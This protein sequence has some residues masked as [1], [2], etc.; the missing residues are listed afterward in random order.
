MTRSLFIYWKAGREHAAA[1]AADAL[2]AQRSL[3]QRHPGLKAR[4][5]RRA[6]EAGATV[7]LMETY[8]RPGGVGAALQAEI[9]LAGARAGAPWCQGARHVEVFDEWRD[10]AADPD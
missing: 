3:A 1:A 8:A 2:A 9:T 7:T 10:G 4:L 5:Y 6:D